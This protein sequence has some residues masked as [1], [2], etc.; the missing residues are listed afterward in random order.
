MRAYAEKGE[1][2]C[3]RASVNKCDLHLNRADFLQDARNAGESGAPEMGLW[4]QAL[5]Q[6][7]RS[8]KCLSQLG[9]C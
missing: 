9:S 6:C 3:A 1:T 5:T 8:E 4:G 2:G 7:F